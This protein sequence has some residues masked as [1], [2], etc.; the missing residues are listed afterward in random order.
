MP[1]VNAALD[2]PAN[3]LKH[4]MLKQRIL[5]SIVLIPLILWILT[6]STQVLAIV[7]GLIIVLGAWEWAGLTGWQT[8]IMRFFYALTVAL[9][10]II[11]YWQPPSSTVTQL[12]LIASCIWWLIALYWLYRHQQG[13][14]LT[15]TQPIIKAIVGILVLLPA[16]IAL[17]T[18][19]AQGWHWVVFLLL[20]IWIA[21]SAAYFVGRRWGRTKLADKISPGKTWEGVIGAIVFSLIASLS[22][23]TFNSMSLVT[24]L[25]FMLLCLI[26]VIVSI[27]GDLLESLFKRQMGV[28]DSGQLLPGHGGLLDRIDSLTSALPIFVVGHLLIGA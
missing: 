24:L 2:A 5:T 13:R 27:I 14:P 15:P 19:H 22:Y 8:K 3:R 9:I 28:K 16:S 6:L 10:L 12:F 20:L 1:A 18:L 25:L 11:L 23:A 17:L 7:I 4:N 21:D 26:T